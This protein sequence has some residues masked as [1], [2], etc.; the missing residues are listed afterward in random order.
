MSFLKLL[1]MVI[2]LSLCINDYALAENHAK[3]NW[4]GHWKD[5]DKREQLVMEIR[6]EFEFLYPKVD[7][8][9]TFGKDLDAP[10]KNRKWK[11]ANTIAQ[12]IKSGNIIWDVI[13]LDF[14]VYNHVAELLGDPDWGKK[15]ILDVS[16]MMWFR[17]SQKDFI[18]NTSHYREQTG[19]LLVGPYIEGFIT[20]LWYNQEVARKTGIQVKERKMT[21]SEFISYARQLADYNKK[22]NTSIPF[23]NLCVWNRLEILFEY[24]YKSL[25]PD[26][27]F[28]IEQ[29]YSQAKEK[30]FLET[31]LIFEELARYQ[32]LL[33]ADYKTLEH[34]QWKHQFLDGGGL[35]IVA[36]TYMY[37]HF[38]GIDPVKF[39]NIIPIIPPFINRENG[40][41]GAYLPTFAVMKNS[42]EREAAINLLK[43]WSRP[44]MAEKWIHYTKNPTGLKGHLHG[45]TSKN[46]GDDVYT[47]F[48]MDMTEQY[49]N[50]PMRYY[51]ALTYIFGENN[52]V[53]PNELRSKLA[54]ILAG[55]L[56]ARQY[57]DDVTRRFHLNH[58]QEKKHGVQ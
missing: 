48:I 16:D 49:S 43:L 25:C 39:K 2:G 5:E 52:V 42:H 18:V 7:V 15:H 21:A 11:H 3:L 29:S 45:L 38:L 33:N 32:P 22:N 50:M 53:T 34:D 26:P 37:S 47:R 14:V 46:M 28:A 56:T 55:K 4:I 54:M 58:A 51:R 13:F 8:N 1:F 9:L 27:Q 10:G 19:G 12:M 35:F 41:V 20:C 23:I 40:L 57:Y 44:R 6:K 17:Q 31:L 24:L 36:G 30:L